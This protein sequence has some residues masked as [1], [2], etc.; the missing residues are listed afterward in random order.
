MFADF[1]IKHA[2]PIIENKIKDIIEGVA[3]KHNLPALELDTMLKYVNDQLVIYVFYKNKTVDK[4]P[5]SDINITETIV[6]H[7]H[8]IFIRDSI[9]YNVHTAFVN[10]VFKIHQGQGL[11][12]N[13]NISG[14]YKGWL[15]LKDIL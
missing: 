4:F 10:Y 1:I 14:D 7:I 2:A 6:K 11:M 8:G 5:L 15:K 13:P 9:L 12:V 3:K